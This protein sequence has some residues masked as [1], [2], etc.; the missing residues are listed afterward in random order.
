MAQTIER[1][2][3]VPYYEQ[4]FGILRDRIV[5]GEFGEDGRLPSEHELCR[6]FGLSRATV[7]QTLAK[8][9]S[10]GHA[11]RIARRGMFAT[12]PSESSSWVVQDT[13]GFLESQIRHGRTGIETTVVS[14]GFVAPPAHV[15]DA[16]GVDRDEDV[17]A[18][19]RVRTLDG[20]VALFST[21]WFPAAVGR[22]VAGAQDVLHG[23]GSLNTMLRGA[24]HVT[25]RAQRVVHALAAP[26][27][28]ARHLEVEPGRAVLRIR[29]RSWDADRTLFD[30][31]ETWV[32]TDVVP[33]EVNVTA[34]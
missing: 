4:L 13:E 8:L 30:Y 15:A 16:L 20:D 24:G 17:F 27:A 12:T 25:A 2:S 32:R 19:E 9:E 31:Y 1:N 5:R 33:L 11:R 34:G 7:R 6:E 26:E 10:E 22:T 3:P 21:N 29:S 28:V 23:V 14:A 18:L